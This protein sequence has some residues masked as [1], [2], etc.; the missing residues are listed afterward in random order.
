MYGG[1]PFIM[2]ELA[3]DMWIERNIPG[4]LNSRLGTYLDN[5]MGGN[6]NPTIPQLY[7]GYGGYG[8]YG[9]YGFYGR[10]FGYPYGGL[11]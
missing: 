3:S 2:A 6:P 10:G 1:N 7:G 5:M 11:Y 4:G 9:G 8:P